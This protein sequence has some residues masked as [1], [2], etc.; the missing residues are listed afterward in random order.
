[1]ATA[2][3][4]LEFRNAMDDLSTLAV[5]DLAA[6]L[7]TVDG[8]QPV[9][10]RNDLIDAFPE[11]VG[12]YVS[13]SGELTATW[14]EDLRGEAFATAYTA[15]AVTDLNPQKVDGLVRWGV[16][17]LFGVSDSTPLSLIGGGV[18]RMI[19]G[20]ARDTIDLNARTDP[21]SVSWARVARPDACEFCKM[22]AGRGSVYRSEAAAGMVI[23]RG[24][25]P[26]QTAGKA[27]GQGRGVRA[28][29]GREVGADKFH[30]FC[31][32][33]AQP[34]FYDVGSWTNPRTGRSQ[35]ALIPIGETAPAEL[36]A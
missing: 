21:A 11:V 4:V 35:A 25:D 29:G 28:R 33:T 2:S 30:D 26:S 8:A 24:V 12:P 32:C 34:T 9:R 14:Y 22:L 5:R 6:F 1:M 13:A 23:G 20:A 31:R 3:Q 18:Q 7:A 36:A 15:R 17:P 16:R 10:V 27:G 19:A